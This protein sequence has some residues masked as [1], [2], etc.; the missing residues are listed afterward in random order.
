MRKLKNILR[1]PKRPW[2][3]ERIEQEKKLLKAYGLRRKGE[4]WKTQSIL[5]A[6]RRKARNLSA[7][8]N[9]SEEKRLLDKLQRLGVF[10]KKATLTDVL[11]LTTEN[12]LERRLQTLIFRKGLSNTIKHARQLI[13]HGHVFI[14]DKK[15]PHPGFM[16]T[17]E[18]ENKISTRIETQ[19]GQ[20]VAE[21]G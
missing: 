6:F 1:K 4:I 8:R 5:R 16:V 12:L 10:E 9:E 17:K 7:K 14:N 3:K 13:T 21:N 11:S 2:D 20:E 19:R 18:L 15:A